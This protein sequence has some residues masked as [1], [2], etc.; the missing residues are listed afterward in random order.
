MTEKNN[1]AVHM[2]IVDNI[3]MV[4][5]WQLTHEPKKRNRKLYLAR[6]THKTGDMFYKIGQCRNYNAEDRFLHDPDQ[7]VDYDI[8]IMASA[9][10]PE[11]EVDAWE[12]RLLNIKKKD[13]WVEGKFS[14]VTEIR[15]FDKGELSYVFNTFQMLSSKWYEE[16]V[17]T[18]EVQ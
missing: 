12:E 17:T 6:F 3:D 8:K 14:G 10:G 5:D 4:T 1:L 2:K 11:D 9:W 15:K 13:F 7:Y 18:S 16:R